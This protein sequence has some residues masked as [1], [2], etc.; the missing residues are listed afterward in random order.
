VRQHEETTCHHKDGE[1]KYLETALDD[2]ID[3][4]R[5]SSHTA[6]SIGSWTN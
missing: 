5:T 4:A 1:A 3:G 2:E 6:V